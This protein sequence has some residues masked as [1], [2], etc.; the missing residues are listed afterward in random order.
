MYKITQSIVLLNRKQYSLKMKTII[1]QFSFRRVPNNI[2]FIDFIFK[3]KHFFQH[4]K[5]KFN[6]FA[7]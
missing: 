3:Q 7:Q 6:E 2:R 1:L 4:F 5:Q